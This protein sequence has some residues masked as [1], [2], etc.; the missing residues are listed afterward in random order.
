MAEGIRVDLEHDLATHQAHPK[1]PIFHRIKFDSTSIYLT[2]SHFHQ[3][4]TSRNKFGHY[5]I[6]SWDDWRAKAFLGFDLGSTSPALGVAQLI[7]KYTPQGDN[8]I[9]V[10]YDSYK[11]KF[12]IEDAKSFISGDAPAGE[13][14]RTAKIDASEFWRMKEVIP[15]GAQG[16]AIYGEGN[17]II[18]GPA[19]TGKSTTV[20]QRV[21]ILM[22]QGIPP[23]KVLLLVKNLRAASTFKNLLKDIGAKGTTVRPFKTLHRSFLELPTSPSRAS[24]DRLSKYAVTIHQTFTEAVRS[25]ARAP[26]SQ[27]DQDEAAEELLTK[28]L[29]NVG[30]A[31]A[32]F[33]RFRSQRASLRKLIKENTKTR[34]NERRKIEIEVN[35]LGAKLRAQASSTLRPGKS[36]SLGDEAKIRDK[37]VKKQAIMRN[38]LDRMSASMTEAEKKLEVRLERLQRKLDDAFYSEETMRLLSRNAQDRIL[39]LPYVEKIAGR[40]KAFHTVI[41]DEAQDASS[42]QIELAYILGLNLILS[43]DELQRESPKGI[44]QWNN[45]Q[46]LGEHFIND[47]ELSVFHLSRNFRQTYE[48]GACSYNFR[49]SVLGKPL[50]DLSGDYFENEKG[51]FKPKLVQVANDDG[52]IVAVKQN[53]EH[54]ARDYTKPFPLVIFYDSE[55]SRERMTTMLRSSGMDTRRDE[56]CKMRDKISFVS[57]EEIAGREFPVVI[58]PLSPRSDSSLIYIMLTRAQFS[59]TLLLMKDDPL[60]KHIARLVSQGWIDKQVGPT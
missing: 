2:K 4:L 30:G 56:N 3:L 13:R 17:F 12:Y 52:F 49:Q 44:G 46:R 50:V 5:R 35:E 43:G 20:I 60:D 39:L 27:V 47:G 22:K 11:G 23:T 53:L 37:Q 45:L 41:V 34:S 1:T 55:S 59:L 7:G 42:V 16:R 29:T 21:R 57:V 8:I 54:I 38:A 36:L 14:N 51:F 28:L 32:I 10:Q 40:D 25:S 6:F 33:A 15:T 9:D 48:L 26:K 18:D 24:M 31:G 58:A 19:G